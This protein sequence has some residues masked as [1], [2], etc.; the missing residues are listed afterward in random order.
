MKSN[1]N[2]SKGSD[3]DAL[4][5]NISELVLDLE[6]QVGSPEL[7]V[8]K[9][10]EMAALASRCN[11][12]DHE[13]YD[14][15]LSFFK[16][17]QDLLRTDEKNFYDYKYELRSYEDGRYIVD[18]E[19]GVKYFDHPYHQEYFKRKNVSPCSTETKSL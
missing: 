12:R 7:L 4:F 15:F 17:V 11:P 5:C 13:V 16:D 3:A 8:T 6:N 9:M 19:E 18:D 14:L 1:F 2:L 10:S